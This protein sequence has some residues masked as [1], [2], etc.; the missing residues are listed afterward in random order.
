MI[1][2]QFLTEDLSKSKV[3]VSLS[4]G[5][6]S[7]ALL[8]YL[9]TEYPT[10]LRPSELYLFYAHLDEHSPDTLAF[11]QACIEYAEKHFTV[12]SKIST[13]S[14]IEFF[15][16][17]NMIPHPMLSPCSRDLKIIPMQEFVAEHGID[18]DLVG[19]VRH[20][21]R[22]IQRQVDRGVLGKLY[23]ISHLTDEDCFE[24][25]D[26][27]IGWHPAIYDIKD[28]SGKQMFSHNNC[29]PC[30]NM[31]GRLDADGATA[32]YKAVEMYFPSQFKAAQELA[33]EIDG[34]WGRKTKVKEESTIDFNDPCL[35]CSF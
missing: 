1:Q 8:C 29:L 35:I 2:S 7:A 27:E 12:T 26:R 9:C 4:G 30:K 25:V 11:V 10:E 19:Y 24:I 34:F 15:R 21:R 28:A 13:G 16:N 18:V 23:P 22:R 6:N 20:E 17:E 33:V 14:V 31:S 3:L 5:I 32:E